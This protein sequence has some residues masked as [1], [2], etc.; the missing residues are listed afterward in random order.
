M[1]IGYIL[2][3]TLRLFVFHMLSLDALFAFGAVTEDIGGVG[4]TTL[5]IFSST[6]LLLVVPSGSFPASID[7]SSLRRHRASIVRSIPGFVSR[8]AE[9]RGV[10]TRRAHVWDLWHASRSA[11]RNNHLNTTFV[12]LFRF[13]KQQ[14][15]KKG[16]RI[17][18]TPILLLL[19]LCND[20]YG[21]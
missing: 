10:S 17:N 18:N 4:C 20:K 11:K 8:G 2:E 13:L 19:K 14:Q 16:R 9:G 21:H 6:S 1:S 7:L 15:Q 3:D 12:F 5:S